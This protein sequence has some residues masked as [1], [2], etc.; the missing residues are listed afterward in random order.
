MALVF[1]IPLTVLAA[2][3]DTGSN[4]V[5]AI[6]FFGAIFGF[7]LGGG[8]A[9]WI[10][11]CGTPLS[12]GMVAAGGTYI[13]AQATFIALRLLTGREVNWFAALFTLSLVLLAG[14]VGGLLGQRLQDKGFVPSS[15]RP[16]AD[17]RRDR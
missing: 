9:A 8:C 6:F 2:I 7:V 16:G 15:R 4:G 14:L 10:Q 5:N 12:H 3:V 11:R 13:I 1:A 17:D